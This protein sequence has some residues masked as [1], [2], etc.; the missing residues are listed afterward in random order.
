MVCFIARN[1]SFVAMLLIFSFVLSG[2][3]KE[4]P[5][6]EL[7]DPIFADLN[8]RAIDAQKSFDEQIKKQTD[9]KAALEK[10]EPNSIEL[11]NA[12]KDLQKA[13]LLA[14]DSE[15]KAHY[16]KIRAQRRMLVDRITYKESF[17]RDQVWPSPHEYSDY[18]VNMRLQESPKNW[19]ARVPKLQERLVK[20]GIAAHSSPKKEGKSEE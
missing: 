14:G 18:L 15:Q 5:E 20:S 11:K 17:A 8:R 4:D 1:F 2:C 13:T 3:K 9:A 6:P 7:L 16:Y 19:N 10:A 12:Q